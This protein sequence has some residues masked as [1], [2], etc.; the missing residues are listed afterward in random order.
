[1]TKARQWR[2]TRYGLAV[3]IVLPAALI[4]YSVEARL[5][6]SGSP[7]IFYFGAIFISAWYGG[8]G[9]GLLTTALTVLSCDYFQVTPGVLFFNR[10]G[11]NIQLAMFLLQGV[12]IC[13]LSHLRFIALRENRALQQ[14]LRRRAEELARMNLAK[15]EFLAMLA[16]EL[17][18]PLAP[19]LTSIQ[20]LRLR[21]PGETDPK[22]TLD[23]IERQAR[24]MARMVDDLLDVSRITRGKIQLQKQRVN[25]VKIV[26]Q[27]VESSRPALDANK[28]A[29]TLALGAEPIWLEADPARLEQIIANL[30]GNAI[31]YTRQGGHLWLRARPGGEQ[32]EFSVRDNGVGIPPEKIDQV[33]ELFNQIDNTLDRS[34]GG[35]GI[36]LT[37]VQRL[38]K[39]HGGSVEARSEGL[40]RGS[41]FIVRLAALPTAAASAPPESS[42]PESQEGRRLRTLVVED[43]A[44][45]ALAMGEVLELWGHEARIAYDGAGAVDVADSYRPEVILLDIGLPGIDGYEVARAL[46][47]QPAFASTLIVAV[48]GYGQA[49][50]LRHAREAGI[51]HHFTKPVDLAALHE[52]LELC[53]RNGARADL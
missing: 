51:D 9:P 20:A 24:H 8:L 32:V 15:D 7:F 45:T 34:Q 46:R 26:E 36:G 22:R 1:M 37:L 10:P 38:V 13:I 27:V 17:R 19:I 53:A 52:L 11:E 42:A 39:L 47:A 6:Y 50:D 3:L 2:R 41:E 33:F 18:N 30:I 31:K 28:Q 29:L 14:A 35:L 4:Q 21:R 5:H 49:E 43:N 40:G 12:L 44:D 16:H 23:M 48:T 25:L